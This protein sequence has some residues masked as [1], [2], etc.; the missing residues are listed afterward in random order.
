[1]TRGCLGRQAEAALLHWLPHS[2][3]RCA[4]RELC[5]VLL[6]M[7]DLVSPEG[8]I[9]LVAARVWKGQV[10]VVVVIAWECGEA[11]QRQARLRVYECTFF[12]RDSRGA[13]ASTTIPGNDEDKTSSRHCTHM[14]RVISPVM[15]KVPLYYSI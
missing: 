3:H 4:M 15:S 13:A 8:R 7:G 14:S 12:E 11:H 9:A 1:M 2:K 5:R 6:W 10:V